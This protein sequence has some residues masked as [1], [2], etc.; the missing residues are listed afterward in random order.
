VNG[1]IDHEQ[2]KNWS[3]RQ[4][5]FRKQSLERLSS[6][7]QLDQLMQVVSPRS[8]L[9]LSVFAGLLLLTLAWSVLGRIP[10][11]ATGQGALVSSEQSD[12]LVGLLYFQRGEGERIRPGMEVIVVPQIVGVERVGGILATVKAV[13]G[14]PV[15]S[16]NDAR[17]AGLTDAMALQEGGI[18]IIAELQTDPDSPSGYRWSGLGSDDIPLVPGT[19]ATARITLEQ[20]APIT[21]VFPFLEID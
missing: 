4:T 21:F 11:T 18:E 16:L 6:P 14:P 2:K 15:M 20:R 3:D 17:Q 12:D 5:I 8:W 19:T 10:I 1:K 9:P 13:T 7:E